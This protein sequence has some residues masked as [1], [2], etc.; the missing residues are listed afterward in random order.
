MRAV[1]QSVIDNIASKQVVLNVIQSKITS[2]SVN[3]WAD[4]WRYEIG[5]NIIPADARN[6]RTWITWSEFQN[7]PIPVKM[8]EHWKRNNMF[9]K[10]MAIIL[11]KVWHNPQRQG[12]YFAL[13]DLDN[14]KGID[15]FCTHNGCNTPLEQL[16]KRMIVEQTFQI[17]KNNIALRLQ[18]GGQ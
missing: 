3:E 10:G 2:W 4:Y 16:A 17:A 5:V 1:I 12:L 9:D 11:R 15:E 8:H 13:I 7:K 6:K 14:Q 18:E